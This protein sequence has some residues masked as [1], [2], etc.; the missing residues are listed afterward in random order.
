M[1]IS[2]TPHRIVSADASELEAQTRLPDRVIL[3]KDPLWL[4]MPTWICAQALFSPLWWIWGKWHLVH[5]GRTCTPQCSRE[6][7]SVGHVDG[8]G[9][10]RGLHND[11]GPGEGR[12]QRD[13]VHTGLVYLVEL[14]TIRISHLTP[15]PPRLMTSCPSVG[16]IP[17]HEVWLPDN[18]CWWPHR[19]SPLQ[20]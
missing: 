7:G 11:A 2:D 9:R 12:C 19:P 6:T 14:S 15:V 17:W 10:S 13:H 5:V 3:E 4:S 1:S 8:S 20:T 18:Q 16:R